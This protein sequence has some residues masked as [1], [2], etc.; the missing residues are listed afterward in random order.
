MIRL[1]PRRS[2][3]LLALACAALAPVAFAAPPGEISPASVPT[4]ASNTLSVTARTAAA[5]EFAGRWGPYVAKTYGVDMRTWARRMAPTFVRADA[6]NIRTALAKPTFEEASLALDGQV[7]DA[8]GKATIARLKSTPMSSQAVRSASATL[9]GSLNSDLVY[10]PVAPCRIVDTRSTAAGVIAANSTRSFVGIN[11]SNFT[12]Q[13]G[14]A[15]N[16][17]TSGLNA[18]ALALNVTAVSP[19]IAG[20]AT[21]YPYGTTQPGTASINYAAGEVVNNGIIAQIPNPLS[22]F[23]FT[24]YSF[25]QAHYVVD[26]VGYFAPPVATALQC[27]DTANTTVANIAVG[28]TANAT[29]PACASGYTQTATNCETSSWSMPIVF[30]HAGTCSAKNN[31]STPQDLRASRTCCRV[32]GR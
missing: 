14:S 31:D 26:I 4:A 5:K 20:Y 21:V 10:T 7:L 1:R 16:C 12:G 6:D 15:T 27:Q 17:G 30:S 13:G 32:P 18:T 22:S 24:I 11:A 29:A 3:A 19:S 9:L 8:A 25:A 28:G 23:D 2:V